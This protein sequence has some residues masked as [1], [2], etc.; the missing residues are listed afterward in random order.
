MVSAPP[1]QL[2]PL[3]NEAHFQ[4]YAEQAEG[5]VQETL[6]LWARG[7]RNQRIAILTRL[8]RRH[9]HST[10]A[11]LEK[12]LG[13]SALLLF[14][15]I[16][17]WLRLTYMLGYELSVQLSAMSLF[18][19]GQK[20]LSAF[21]EVGG[22]QLLTDILVQ[23]S[24]MPPPGFLDEDPQKV[25]QQQPPPTSSGEANSKHPQTTNNHSSS[26]RGGA[27][28]AEEEATRRENKHNCVLL[29]LHIA[30]SGRVYREMVCDGSGTD[31][32]VRATLVETDDRA[33]ELTAALLLALGQGNPRKAV[34][35]HSG[36]IFLMQ[37][38]NEAA[39]LC[40]ATTLRSLQLAKEAPLKKSGA[41]ESTIPLIGAEGGD[42]ARSEV[43]LDAFFR[44]LS[45]EHVKL[46]FEGAELLHLAAKN[47]A[48]TL[49]V[50]A[51]CL[52]RIDDD[53]L[54]IVA[55]A[56]AAQRTNDA[57]EDDEDNREA[58]R[59]QP[60]TA[61]QQ[62][63]H[64]DGDDDPLVAP[65]AAAGGSEEAIAALVRTQRQ[66]IACGRAVLSI[67]LRPQNTDDHL[68][69][70]LA[71]AERRSAY[72]SLL[73]YLR[74]AETKD[75]GGVTD[76]VRAMQLLCR[77]SGGAG[78][79]SSASSFVPG[80]YLTKASRYVAANL[81]G[82]ASAG[83]GGIGS[84]SGTNTTSSSSSGGAAGGGEAA[85]ES[86]VC[87]DVTD[88]IAV[89]FVE[90]LKRADRAQQELQEGGGV[91]GG[92]GGMMSSASLEGSMVVASAAAVGGGRRTSAGAAATFVGGGPSSR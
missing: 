5:T 80:R 53:G 14:T 70:L 30:N 90:R 77:G 28:D 6:R 76:G 42:P 27:R 83:G 41:L 2:A 92:I 72:M 36:L 39:A 82:C 63:R 64:H 4:Q 45:M 75:V 22:I 3:S 88:D 62:R 66:Q 85:Y 25:Q 12:S 84:S 91:G 8:V 58:T 73:K 59:R 11:E 51:R 81:F 86:F 7:S 50:L 10:S 46:R 68:Q 38:G 40:A 31:S 44:L 71:F 87:E 29:L 49:P 74:L 69:R 16:T 21:M 32:I 54:R 61:Q 20:F 24:P 13:H 56:S 9:R 37:H 26:S 65:A 35:V 67:L 1:L 17:A 34:L 89:S 19:Q 60:N 79:G 47:H 55:G 52:D 23:Q 57:E 33:L 15:H 18:L 43:L 78:S 48:L